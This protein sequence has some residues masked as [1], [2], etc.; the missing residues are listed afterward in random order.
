[1]KAIFRGGGLLFLAPSGAQSV[2]R[3]LILGVDESGAISQ[4]Q[5]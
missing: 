5:T 2:H 1:M 3:C 4:N